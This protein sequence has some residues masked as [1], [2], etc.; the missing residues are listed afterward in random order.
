MQNLKSKLKTDLKKRCFL[1]SLEIIKLVDSLPNS[2]SC[3]VIGDQVMRSGTSI[4]ANLIEGSAASSR[5]EFKKFHE[6]S[7]KSANETIYWLQL[8]VFSHKLP[9]SKLQPVLDETTQIS[10]MLAAG[11]LRLK[12]K[13]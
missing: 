9:K 11:I 7:L 8:L 1:L 2:R 10:K 3:W 4:G 5:R 12:G 6:I 13:R